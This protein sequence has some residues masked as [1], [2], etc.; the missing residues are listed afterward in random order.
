VVIPA[1]YVER[2]YAGVLG[3]I[4]GVY[5]GRPI[6]N[7]SYERIMAE[8]G[9]INYYV[10]DRRNLP[11]VVTDDDITGAFTFVRALADY[12]GVRPLPPQL[13]GQTWLNYIIEGKSILWWGGLGNSTEHTA[14]L[15]LR[16]GIPAPGSGSSQ[17]NGKIIAEQIGAQIFVDG[18]AMVAPGNPDLAA[19]L[20]RQAASVSHDGEA[21]YAAQVLA[22]ME[23]LAFVEPDLTKLL[24][25]AVTFIPH[26]SVI[27][28]LIAD[29][30]EWRD[31]YDDWRQARGLIVSHYGYEKYR[32]NCHVV[33][34]HALI[35]L[36]LLYG[37]DDFQKSLMITNT[38]G[39]DTDCNSGNVGCLLG[40]KN[41]LRGLSAGPDWRSPVADRLYL[42]TA[43]G[44]RAISDAVTET[45][46]LANLGL[47]LAGEMPL[48]P[49]QGARYHFDLP[50]AMQGF[51]VEATPEE[52]DTIRLQNV[53]DH[54][55]L[56]QRSLAIHYRLAPGQPA[57]IATD[58]FIP[59]EDLSMAG[60]HLHACPS[61]YPGQTVTA[62]LLADGANAGPVVV[63]LCRQVYGPQD[64][65]V[66]ECG[67]QRWLN[68]GEATTLTWK[69]DDTAGQPIA[70]MGLELSSA[71]P[72]AG[73]VYLDYMTWAGEP[74][75]VFMR[76]QGG[77]G[78]WR[79]WLPGVSAL[80]T[81][82]PEPFR[83]IQNHGRGLLIQGGRE[84][85]NYQVQAILTPH[86]ARAYGLAA[87]VQGLQRYYAFLLGQDHQARLV[88]ALDGETVLA[89]TAFHWE[90]GSG[91]DM[92][93]QVTGSRLQ[94]WVGSR[95]LFDVEDS[96][97]PLNGGAMA[98]VCEEG[99][100]STDRVAVRPAL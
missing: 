59:P 93:L 75:L 66:P 5:L 100:I 87:R 67:P 51:R 16:Q 36:G 55:E 85:A 79:A 30:R 61:L 38:S 98:L 62:R 10:H 29:L 28:R 97:C 31:R 68:P 81:G 46:H 82:W 32:G 52:D 70:R 33:P 90:A 19:D 99:C 94:A 26:D 72:V 45:F 20:A 12:P 76:P 17:L 77:T 91:Y 54:S 53:A 56:G 37:G 18:W 83:V 96:G 47:S 78:W 21:I 8:L 80:D 69:L 24:D 92:T 27:Y 65:L 73:V 71:H 74:D 41:G 14:Y 35:H 6:E 15:R 2:V 95:Q 22:A 64:R 11:L 88:K 42:P 44:G 60:Y 1:D 43:D 58:T 89:A 4:I 40:I 3:K 9:E 57:R 49:K 13:I 34:N 86:L 23:A 25:T 84:W 39:W 7:W 63:R 50:G 48:A